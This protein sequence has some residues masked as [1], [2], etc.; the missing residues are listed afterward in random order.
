MNELGFGVIRLPY[1]L[2]QRLCPLVPLILNVGQTDVLPHHLQHQQ[3]LQK[4][5][6]CQGNLLP[7]SQPFL[8]DL[9]YDATAQVLVVPQQLIQGGVVCQPALGVVTEGFDNFGFVSKVWIGDLILHHEFIDILW[10]QISAHS[11]HTAIWCWFVEAEIQEP[12]KLG[13]VLKKAHVYQKLNTVYMYY[14]FLPIQKTHVNIY[15]KATKFERFQINLCIFF[16]FE[17]LA[18]NEFYHP[19]CVF[20]YKQNPKCFGFL[21]HLN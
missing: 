15:L 6:C 20:V 4:F 9:I 13:E 17:F 14:I 19:V 7:G 12:W 10:C 3:A 1:T 5:S 8:Y 2:G 21:I 18:Y 11:Y 16:S